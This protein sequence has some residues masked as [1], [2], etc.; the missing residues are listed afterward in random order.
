MR[1]KMPLEMTEDEVEQ[2]KTKYARYITPDIW[3]QYA[4]MDEF[5]QDLFWRT[6][7]ANIED[8]IDEEIISRMMAA[9]KSDRRVPDEMLSLTPFKDA[10]ESLATGRWFSG[11]ASRMMG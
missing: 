6:I 2:A 11:S 10:E 5:N 3:L 8:A 1:G 4:Q 9:H 7:A